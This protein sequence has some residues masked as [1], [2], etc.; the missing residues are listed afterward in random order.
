MSFLFEKLG[1]APL[2][3]GSALASADGCPVAP[4]SWS[5]LSLTDVPQPC[6]RGLSYL[7]SVRNLFLTVY[8]E[9]LTCERFTATANCHRGHPRIVRT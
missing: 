1:V 8:L 6:W 2:L 3:K 4:C 9:G 7:V 5:D